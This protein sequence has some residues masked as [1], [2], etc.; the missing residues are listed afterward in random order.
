MVVSS[1]P[2]SAKSGHTSTHLRALLV[3]VEPQVLHLRFV[4]T[5]LR[6]TSVLTSIACLRP[7]RR[8]RPLL[9]TALHGVLLSLARVCLRWALYWRVGERHQPGFTA[10]DPCQPSLNSLHT[11]HVERLECSEDVSEDVLL[12]LRHGV[13]QIVRSIRGPAEIAS[14]VQARALT[15]KSLCRV[16][17]STWSANSFEATCKPWDAFTLCTRS[18]HPPFCPIGSNNLPSKDFFFVC[19]FCGCCCGGSWSSVFVLCKMDGALGCTVIFYLYDNAKHSSLCGANQTFVFLRG[20]RSS[21]VHRR[22]DPCGS[23]RR[24][25]CLR[26][27]DLLVMSRCLAKADRAHRFSPA[28]KS[29]KP[30]CRLFKGQPVPLWVFIVRIRPGFHST[31][32][33]DH[34]LCVEQFSRLDTKSY[35]FVFRPSS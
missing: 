11:V 22:S 1:E 5:L 25:L 16:K 17:F 20:Q 8:R 23:R 33:L 10:D 24:N 15:A 7:R 26:K 21:T 18:V 13:N 2:S 4:P 19:F 6:A 30:S 28:L 14:N 3:F 32:I 35:F 9:C 34:L 29:C 31:A 27:W 12:H